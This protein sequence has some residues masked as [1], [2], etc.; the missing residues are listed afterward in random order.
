MLACECPVAL[1]LP[2]TIGWLVGPD[3]L[4][5]RNQVILCTGV[6]MYIVFNYMYINYVFVVGLAL[7]EEAVDYDLDSEDDEWLSVQSQE[8][9]GSRC[10]MMMIT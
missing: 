3:I 7:D 8:R 5:I 10:M 4:D 6:R 1:L 2:G 9:V